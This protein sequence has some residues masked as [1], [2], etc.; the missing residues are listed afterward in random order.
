MAGSR[1]LPKSLIPL[2]PLTLALLQLSGIEMPADIYLHAEPWAVPALLQ[3]PTRDAG[4]RLALAEQAA[5]QG[6]I[7]ASDLEVIY[8]SFSPAPV[9]V[10]KGTVPPETDS[11]RRAMLYQGALKDET[12]AGR[13]AAAEKWLQITSP[14][15]L[16][17]AASGVVA[18]MTST[19]PATP[20]FYAAAPMMVRINLMAGKMAAAT[21]WLKRARQESEKPATVSSDLLYLWPLL[22]LSGAEISTDYATSRDHWLDTMLHGGNTG[23]DQS[24]RAKAAAVLLLLDASGLA[25]SESNWSSVVGAMTAESGH[26][27]APA[28]VLERMRAAGAASR[29]G[30]AVVLSVT[31]AG[32]S[33]DAASIT[34]LEI[35]RALRAVGL[36]GDATAVA[37]EQAVRVLYSQTAP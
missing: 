37:R 5:R 31:A 33:P 18:D 6:L 22:V 17:G 23:N 1:V 16:N 7:T 14:A 11:C 10:Q 8:G 32:V 29:R 9:N 21:D 2:S 4:A 30:E 27:D 24:M 28:L 13:L 36:V 3:M 15:L 26:Q 35:I 20:D 25:V 34:T 19:V 12:M